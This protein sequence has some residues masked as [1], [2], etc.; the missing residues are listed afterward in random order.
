MKTSREQEIFF[1]SFE[2]NPLR[3][4]VNLCQSLGLKPCLDTEVRLHKYGVEFQIDLKLLP[5]QA[6]RRLKRLV[7]L[8]VPT[9]ALQYKEPALHGSW[10]G[11]VVPATVTFI[12]NGAFVCEQVGTRLEVPPEHTLKE[13]SKLQAMTAE[14]ALAHVRKLASEKMQPREVPNYICKPS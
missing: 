2:V 3:A 10:Q 5:P 7:D 13:A 12:C 9:W 6:R 4:V 11:E 14:E 1:N 8:K